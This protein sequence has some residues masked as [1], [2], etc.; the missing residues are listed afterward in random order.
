MNKYN[1][2]LKI[3]ENLSDEQ[4]NELIY[5]KEKTSYNIENFLKELCVN[6]RLLG[7]TYLKDAIELCLI[8]ENMLNS[9]TKEL[10]PTIARN[11]CTTPSRV[12]RAIRHAI[13]TSWDKID[14]ETYHDVFF[15]ELEKLTNSKYIA[16]VCS[17]INLNNKQKTIR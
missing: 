5:Q 6:P 8:D 9:I 17:Y 3:L 15:N 13:M 12:E 2:I 10:Y 1:K 4:I 16:Y 11:N 14:G 7:F